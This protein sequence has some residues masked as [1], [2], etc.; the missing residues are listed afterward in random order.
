[1]DRLCAEADRMG[2]SIHD[3]IS[4]LKTRLQNLFPAPQQAPHASAKLGDGERFGQVVVGA[5]VKTL[6][7]VPDSRPVTGEH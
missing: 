3:E 7:L 2:S 4:G 5:D 6:D 1:M